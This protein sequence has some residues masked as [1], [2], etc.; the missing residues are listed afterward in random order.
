[1]EALQES[2]KVE[3]C[4]KPNIARLLQ[5]IDENRLAQLLLEVEKEEKASTKQEK[6]LHPLA[7]YFADNSPFD[8]LSEKSIQTTHEI[9]QGMGERLFNKFTPSES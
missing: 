9:R 2:V 3:R 7:R 5:N 4:F 6:K 1:M 8:G